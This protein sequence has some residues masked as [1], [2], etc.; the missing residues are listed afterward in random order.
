MMSAGPGALNP[1]TGTPA[2]MASRMTRPKVSVRDGK[3]NTSAQ[4]K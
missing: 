3:T 2:A 1:A 4:P